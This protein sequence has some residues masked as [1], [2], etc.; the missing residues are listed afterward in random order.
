MSDAAPIEPLELEDVPY[1]YPE[2][3]S[4]A[5]DLDVCYVDEGTGAVPLLF[6]PPAG[7]S[8]L[9][10]AKL[11][12]P[13]LAAGYRVIAVDPPG[14]GKSGKPDATYSIEWYLHWLE[15]FVKA[16]GLSRVVLVGSSMGG[17]LAGTFAA[18]HP[19]LVA[20]AALVAPAGGP[21][22]FVKRQVLGYFLAEER[23]R[24]A[25]PRKWRLALGQYFHR[26]IPELEELVVRGQR[27][28]LSKGWGAYCRAVSRGG[29]AV[30]AFDLASQLGGLRA[31]TLLLWGRED[32]VC[33]V[34]WADLFGK[35]L[36]RKRVRILE[37]CG[38]FPS[39]EDPARVEREL[40][41][42]LREDVPDLAPGTAPG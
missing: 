39:I 24:D 11:Y 6:L 37:G 17:L 22:P 26:P 8:L 4:R 10:D 29:K 28:A 15:H 5:A 13:L 1:P 30:L 19:A 40:L 14:W 12:A 32:R 23:L 9:H 35:R 33:P 16:L 36:S 21:I 41:A 31:P 38:H 25:S 20:G 18:R 2:K 27:V 7:R 3:R 34:A 42:W